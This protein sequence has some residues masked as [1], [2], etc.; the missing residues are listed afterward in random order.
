[1]AFNIPAR[2]RNFDYEAWLQQNGGR[3][4]DGD[5]ESSSSEAESSEEEEEVERR[6]P[7]LV[8]D[9]PTLRHRARRATVVMPIP[10]R[11]DQRHMVYVEHFE[12]V[13]ERFGVRAVQYRFA[14][15]TV[16]PDEDIFEGFVRFITAV[17]NM[18]HREFAPEDYVQV[19]LFSSDLTDQRI[20]APLVR[21]RDASRDVL[22]DTIENIMQSNFALALDS[23]DLTIEIQHVAM[24]EARGYEHRRKH[25]LFTMKENMEWVLKETKS[26]AEVPAEMDPF[27]SVL[28]LLMAKEWIEKKKIG[29]PIKNFR[30]EFKPGL[31]LR[32]QCRELFLKAGL[33][34]NSGLHFSQFEKLAGLKE[35]R[36]F[37]ILVYV[38]GPLP[39]L[40]I[41][42]LLSFHF[43]KIGF[44]LSPGFFRVRFGSAEN[45]TA[46]ADCA[47]FSLG[48]THPEHF[49]VQLS[50]VRISRPS[51][52][53]RQ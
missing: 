48:I 17:Y 34:L 4:D 28:S 3:G 32:R 46:L 21:V 43:V 5:D 41:G 36:Q 23:G 51:Q 45:E 47:V 16:D 30:R 7:T 49:I 13:S 8:D 9:D 37:E 15:S 38:C 6:R 20:G 52:H 44:A 50:V 1:M 35:F 53:A 29:K 25:L 11:V 27:C 22:I 10:R 18:I 33:S 24:P 14:P 26:L 40:G 42:L 19:D 2:W 39:S 12:N 31:K